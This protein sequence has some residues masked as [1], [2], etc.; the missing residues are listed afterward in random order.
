MNEGLVGRPSQRCAAG[1]AVGCLV[2][3]LAFAGC[4]GGG[5]AGEAFEEG[6]A[7]NPVEAMLAIDDV[8]VA[9]VPLARH[10]AAAAAGVRRGGTPV[11]ARL[12]VGQRLVVDMEVA[13]APAGSE[14]SV[15]WWRPDGR[16]VWRQKREVGDE[17]RLAFA[18]DTAGWPGGLYRGE[19][20]YGRESLHRV[21]VQVG[22][23]APPPAVPRTAAAPDA[24]SR[25][26]EPPPS[27]GR[28]ADAAPET[29]APPAADATTPAATSG[30]AATA[31][32]PAAPRPLDTGS[33]RSAPAEP[34][35]AEPPPPTEPADAPPAEPDAPPPP[36]PDDEPPAPP[37]PPPDDEDDEP[38]A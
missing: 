9:G 29:A 27:G 13:D 11:I 1:L 10:P 4:R 20:R 35:T 8:R 7:V 38:P 15:A 18:A 24:A 34:P 21:V 30:R 23:L 32:S 6:T 37:A 36:P 19:I 14:V 2:A 12:A 16:A 5:A 33:P 25:P 28:V 3:G 31:P 17:P 26:G 22:S